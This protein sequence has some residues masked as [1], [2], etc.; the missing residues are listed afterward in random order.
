MIK[1]AAVHDEGME[2][3]PWPPPA[4]PGCGAPPAAPTSRGSAPSHFRLRDPLSIVLVAVIVIGFAAAGVLASELYARHR[5]ESVV[6]AATE[7]AVRWAPSVQ[8]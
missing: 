6:A 4:Q 2:E 8:M 1:S 7:C 3:H 5:A